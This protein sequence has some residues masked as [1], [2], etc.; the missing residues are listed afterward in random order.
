[1]RG[2]FLYAI[3]MRFYLKMAEM[4]IYVGF[5]DSKFI[6]LLDVAYGRVIITYRYTMKYIL[7][8]CVYITKDKDFRPLYLLRRDNR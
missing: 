7:F 2:S 3:I 6:T 1:M 5:N 8:V 4:G